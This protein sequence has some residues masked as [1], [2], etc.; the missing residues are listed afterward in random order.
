MRRQQCK[1]DGYSPCYGT[2]PFY[3]MY[4]ELSGRFQY[5]LAQEPVRRRCVLWYQ[6][7]CRIVFVHVPRI[8]IIL[9]LLPVSVQ[10]CCKSVGYCIISVSHFSKCPYALLFTR[11]NLVI[12]GSKEKIGQKKGEKQYAVSELNSSVTL[13]L[14]HVGASYFL[15]F[16]F[17]ESSLC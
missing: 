11:W 4:S 6:Q 7:N 12:N 3:G 5:L 14:S 10:R 17:T 2:Y 15:A 9:V 1:N 13:L 16:R 8:I